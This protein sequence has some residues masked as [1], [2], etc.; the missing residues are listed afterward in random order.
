MYHIIILQE[1]Q[2]ELKLM[3]TLNPCTKLAG[4]ILEHKGCYV[5]F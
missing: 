3:T 1:L 2:K 5:N 4:N